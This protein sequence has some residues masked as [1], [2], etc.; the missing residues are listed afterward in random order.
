MSKW[1]TLRELIKAEERLIFARHNQPR[2]PRKAPEST[3][4]S[5]ETEQFS[6]CRPTLRKELY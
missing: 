6:R 1:L 2:S 4:R 5:T 3:P